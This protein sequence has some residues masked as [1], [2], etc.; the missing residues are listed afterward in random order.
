MATMNKYEHK[1]VIKDDDPTRTYR[2]SNMCHCLFGWYAPEA[3][4]KAEVSA[5]IE[6]GLMAQKDSLSK[7][8]FPLRKPA[9]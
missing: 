3:L 4:T 8:N 5:L 6:R 7:S 2:Q 1:I 9:V